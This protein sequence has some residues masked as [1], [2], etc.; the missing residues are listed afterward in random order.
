[1]NDT[2]LINLI[3][4]SFLD[5]TKKD[6]LLQYLKLKGIDTRFFNLFNEYLKEEVAKRETDYDKEAHKIDSMLEKL[7][8]EITRQK[9]EIEKKVEAELGNIDQTDI[10][11]KTRIWDEYYEE[12]EQLGEIYKNGLREIIFQAL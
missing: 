9:M 1:M 8:N 7:E 4:I 5:Q 11:N 6:Y 3:E 2:K 10:K 12:L